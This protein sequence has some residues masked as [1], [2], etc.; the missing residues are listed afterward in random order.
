MYK[1]VNHCRGSRLILT[2]SCIGPKMPVPQFI[3]SAH[4]AIRLQW[5]KTQELLEKY[6]QRPCDE[7]SEQNEL[8]EE[9]N[10]TSHCG[11]HAYYGHFSV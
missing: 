6:T 1:Y 10:V 8:L 9:C 7:K 11:G 3:E 4:S 5:C 2:K